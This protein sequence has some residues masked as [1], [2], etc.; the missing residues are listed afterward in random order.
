MG[1]SKSQGVSQTEYIIILALIS[2]A[3]L[4]VVGD[5]GVKIKTL[6]KKSKAELSFE[7]N[8]SNSDVENQQTGS[9]DNSNQDN[10][11]SSL[12]ANDLTNEENND[13]DNTMSEE[14]QQQYNN[15]MSQREQKENYFNNLIN[16]YN[17]LANYYRSI[18]LQYANSYLWSWGGF[19]HHHHHHTHF[20]NTQIQRYLLFAQF[21]QNKA[22]S[23][24]NALNH[25]LNNWQLQMDEWEQNC[26]Q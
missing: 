8:N 22:N 5:L 16:R 18:A 12:T 6:F 2:L 11:N 3:S 9:S 1:K 13:E 20:T 14:C 23:A 25:F 15:L 7:N 19:W 17:S 26:Q 21:Y 24:Q 4:L 10:D